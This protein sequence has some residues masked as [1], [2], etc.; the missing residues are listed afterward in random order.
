M[1][2]RDHIIVYYSVQKPKATTNLENFFEPLL[3]TGFPAPR[4]ASRRI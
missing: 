2:S 1:L 3:I 4:I